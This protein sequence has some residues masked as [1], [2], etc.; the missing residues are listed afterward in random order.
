MLDKLDF[1]K[2]FK[3]QRKDR[4]KTTISTIIGKHRKAI[5]L[6]FSLV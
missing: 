2:I 6:N 4:L 5:S 3:P 1:T